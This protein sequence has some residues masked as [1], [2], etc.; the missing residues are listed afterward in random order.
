MIL[1]NLTDEQAQMMAATFGCN[2]ATFPFTY[3]GIPIGTTKPK[4]EDLMPLMDKS[5]R[6]LAS[7]SSLLTQAARLQLVNLVITSLAT[8]TMCIIK[9]PTGV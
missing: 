7:V 5:E 3:I 2:L 6:R 8:Y 4:I 9:I 1:I